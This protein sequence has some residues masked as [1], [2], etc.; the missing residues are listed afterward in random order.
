[1]RKMLKELLSDLGR[2][3]GMSLSLEPIPLE[4]L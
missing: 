2:S 3:L 4:K 1:V